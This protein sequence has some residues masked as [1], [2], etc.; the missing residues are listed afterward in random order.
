MTN[1]S[2]QLLQE[3]IINFIKNKD[4]LL[5]TL[6]KIDKNTENFELKVSYKSKEEYIII[7]PFIKDFNI[8]LEKLDKEK[9]ISI[10]LFNFEDNLNKI[11]DNWKYLAEFEKLTIYFVN[12]FSATDQKWIIKP[13]LHNRIAEQKS[14]KQGLISM[15]NMVEPI[16]EQEVETKTL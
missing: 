11:L 16:T 2:K 15:F 10:V 7:D 6:E 8:I 12:M 14:L 1:K 3:W 4:T 9:Y 13:S 5:N